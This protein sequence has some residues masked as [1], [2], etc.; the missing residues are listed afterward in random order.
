MMKSNHLEQSLHAVGL[1]D[2]TLAYQ[3]FIKSLQTPDLQYQ[4]TQNSDSSP[5]SLCFAIFGLK[6]MG[7]TQTLEKNS[8]VYGKMLRDCLDNYSKERIL[9]KELKLDKPFLQLLSFT[10]SALDVLGQ[11]KSDPLEEVV[12]SLISHDIK[13]DLSTVRALEG[14]PG[15]GNMAMFY[16]I[17]LIHARDYLGKNTGLLIDE[18]ASLHM[19]AMNRFGFWGRCKGMTYLQ[20]Q[21]GYHQYQ[22]FEYLG[23]ENRMAETAA[24]NVALMV[25]REGH[26]APYPGGGGCFDYDAVFVLTSVGAKALARYGEVL[27]QVS[28]SILDG[29]NSDGGFGETQYVRPRSMRNILVG[30]RHI[31]ATGKMQFFERLRFFLTLQRPKHNRIHTHWTKY[32]REWGESDLW[33]S[34]FRMLAL[35]RIERLLNPSTDQPCGFLDYP[36]IGHSKI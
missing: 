32:S 10:L 19:S 21:N 28:L 14:A 35:A 31:V 12:S 22:M 2:A 16:I 8:D 13:A 24:D 23:V 18:W 34:W 17:L 30:M 9:E 4:F 29:Q 26:F 1:S 25:D 6:L 15:S 27:S 5:F 11:L 33:D 20:F 3:E 7:D 36:G